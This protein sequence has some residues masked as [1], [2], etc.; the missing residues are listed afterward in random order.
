MYAGNSV[1][2]A[3]VEDL[4]GNPLHPYTQGLLGAVPRLDEIQEELAII[5]GANP[6]LSRRIEGCTFRQ[7]CRNRVDRCKE[8]K[9]KWVEI[10][11]NHYIA[12]CTLYGVA[13]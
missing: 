4:F 12:N 7:R 9:P 10:E 11:K 13:R 1:E 3:P 2:S 5:P 8:L 6:D